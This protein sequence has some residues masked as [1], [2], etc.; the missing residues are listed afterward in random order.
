M[1]ELQR[2]A[3]KRQGRKRIL[4]GL[5]RNLRKNRELDGKEKR[6]KES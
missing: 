4:R 5:N 1:D 6:R 3:K 2:Q